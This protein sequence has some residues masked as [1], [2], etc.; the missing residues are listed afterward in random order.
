MTLFVAPPA[1]FSPPDFLRDA[2]GDGAEHLVRLRRSA[3]LAGTVR[4]PDGRPA[5]RILVIA[6]LVARGWLPTGV[7]TDD[8]GR[9]VFDPIVPGFSRMIAVD[10]ENWA[11]PS[12]T[13]DVLREGQEQ[14]GLD[15]TLSKG[16][17]VRGR[18]A[19]GAERQPVA[20]LG[21]A[22]IEE[23]GPLPKELR[24]VRASAYRLARMTSTDAHGDYQ[25]RLAPG[26]YRLQT[27]GIDVG[28]PVAIVVHNEAEIVHDLVANSH[29]GESYISGVVVEKTATGDRPVGGA[30]AFR[31]PVYGVSRADDQGRF[32][33]EGTPGETTLYAFCP[34]KSL[35]GF[36]KV[37]AGA[38]TARV[39]VAKTG[40]VTGRVIDSNGK[41]LAKQRVR[42]QLA[43]GPYATSPA[44]FAVSVL[45][46]DDQGRFTYNDAP[47]GSTGEFEAFHEKIGAMRVA[48]ERR[49]PRTVV[50]FEVVDHD[51][52]QVPDLVIPAN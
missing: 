18:V 44:H 34:G 29:A 33:V 39:V 22:L 15:F 12:L 35:A 50:P 1:G 19:T 14:R 23:G 16:T 51:P 7:R 45:M 42:V 3:R 13:S 47:V 43:S 4:L 37:P 36:A 38:E 46:T 25:F 40:A 26:R 20:Y 28:E 9:Y 31:W 30:M 8:A 48:L 21:V 11:A 2:P 5:R 27:R 24:T 32:M 49:G 10:D 52:V 6:G 41:P 17:L